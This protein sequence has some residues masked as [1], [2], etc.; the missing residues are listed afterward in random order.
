[1]NDNLKYAI[2][3]IRKMLNIK[4]I[5]QVDIV[6]YTEE[7]NSPGLFWHGKDVKIKL[8][9]VHQYWN[10]I[11]QASHEM[12]HLAFL[13]NNNFKNHINTNWVEEI[14]CEGFSIYCLKCFAREEHLQWFGYLK[15]DFYLCN[16]NCKN[17]AKV[18]SLKELNM[19]LAGVKSY[20]IRQLIHPTALEVENIIERNISELTR[21]LDFHSY[22]DGMKIKKDY[23]DANKIANAILKFQKGLV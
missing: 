10:L 8:I 4:S 3:E 5:P 20:E 6:S 15:P 12:L 11:Y 23:A 2:D 16:G 21:F 14:V 17:A 7:N 1:M 22:T 9:D 13:E 18:S 19:E